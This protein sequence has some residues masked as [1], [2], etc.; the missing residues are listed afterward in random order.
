MMSYVLRNSGLSSIKFLCATL[1]HMSIGFRDE[2]KDIPVMAG[3][4]LT[5]FVPS[6]I[7]DKSKWTEEKA[8]SLLRE[9]YGDDT[10]TVA[11]EFKDAYPEVNV[12]YAASLDLHV[13]PSVIEFLEK[14]AQQ[15]GAKAYSYIMTFE[16]PYLG[17]IMLGH[18]TDLHFIFHNA[19]QV[20]GMVKEGVTARLQ[21]EMAGAWAAFARTGDPNHAK[22]TVTWEPF[23]AEGHETYAFGD[24]SSL[25]TNHDLE[26]MKFG[27]KY[28]GGPHASKKKDR[29]GILFTEE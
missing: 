28:G 20:E 23:T 12:A 7:G 6:P 22:M 16:Q 11:G 24:V 17:G 19:L 1:S 8:Y 27:K 25:K 3:S 4:I 10:P 2:T 5:E 18:N 29:H 14:K 26:L 9:R 21:D 15:G 13:R